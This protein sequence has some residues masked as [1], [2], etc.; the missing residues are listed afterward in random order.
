MGIE[1]AVKCDQ[2]G[3]EKGITN[4]WVLLWKNGAGHFEI[5]SW[6]Y[7]SAIDDRNKLNLCGARCLHIILSRKMNDGEL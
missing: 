6:D 3:I 1:T 2:C 4:H 7:N 5:A